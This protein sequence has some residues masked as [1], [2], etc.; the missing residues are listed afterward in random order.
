MARSS[1]FG[2]N[3]KQ[4]QNSVMSLRP[5]SRL[6]VISH[7]VT[8]CARSFQTD[9]DLE[10]VVRWYPALPRFIKTKNNARLIPCP[11]VLLFV[12]TKNGHTS[13]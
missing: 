5:A 3:E 13:G 12:L 1:A 4:H 10:D 7:A 6:N 8:P 9:V 11:C 2:L